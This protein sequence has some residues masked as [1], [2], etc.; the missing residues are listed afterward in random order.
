MGFLKFD[1]NDPTHLTRAPGP[2]VNDVENVAR[3]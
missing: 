2:R 3:H 1:E